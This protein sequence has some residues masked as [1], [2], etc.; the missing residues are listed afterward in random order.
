MVPGFVAMGWIALFAP[1]GTPAPI[2]RKVNEALM[3][4][5]AD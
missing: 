4:K 2:I 3:K 1:A 5:T